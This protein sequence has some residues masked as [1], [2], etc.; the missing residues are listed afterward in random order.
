MG[1]IGL[2]NELISSNTKDPDRDLRKENEGLRKLVV[3][4]QSEAHRHQA[5]A[6]RYSARITSLETA[7]AALERKYRDMREKVMK[8][9]ELINCCI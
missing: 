9:F 5:E 8:A 1:E 6:Q 7:Y 2:G 3:H 4:Y